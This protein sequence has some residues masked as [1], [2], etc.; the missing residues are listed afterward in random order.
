MKDQKICSMIV[1]ARLSILKLFILK[2]CDKGKGERVYVISGCI[3]IF[4]MSG[5]EVIVEV[6][7][8]DTRCRCGN[9]NTMIL[10][11]S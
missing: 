6:C 8:R 11:N 1:S 5:D 7:R 9:D 3:F 4:L 10:S 2:V